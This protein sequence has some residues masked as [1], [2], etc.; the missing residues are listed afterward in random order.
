MQS[1]YV[2]IFVRKSLSKEDLKKILFIIT[3]RTAPSALLI[4]RFWNYTIYTYG[5]CLQPNKKFSFLDVIC[6]L[7]TSSPSVYCRLNK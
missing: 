5:L 3:I 4:N 6:I 2:N 1:T 7:H